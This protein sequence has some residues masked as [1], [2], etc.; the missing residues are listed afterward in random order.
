M[1]EVNGPSNAQTPTQGYKDMKNQR[2]NDISKKKN[3][4]GKEKTFGDDG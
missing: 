3:Q 2:K 4:R 1:E